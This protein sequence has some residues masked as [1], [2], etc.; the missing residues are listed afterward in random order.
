VAAHVPAPRRP[1]GT[2]P[3]TTALILILLIGPGCLWRGYA[4]VMRIH[5][6]VL[7]GLAEKAAFNAGSG[8][9]PSSNDVTELTY[10]LQRAR[11]FVYQYRS[12]A[13]RESY[14][15]FA[16]ALDRYQAFA[17]AIDAAR[18]DE[19][20]WAAERPSIEARYQAWQ[21]AADQVRAALQHEL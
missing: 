12:Y 1:A 4:D 5:L 20:R 8:R 15:L 16:S 19:A 7:S 18:G 11:Q 13:D 17:D 9:R 10:P 6:D 21:A 3:A 2:S 14:R